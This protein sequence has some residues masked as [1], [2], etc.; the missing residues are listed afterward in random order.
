[1][2]VEHSTLV[3]GLHRLKPVTPNLWI[4]S[5]CWSCSSMA[6]SFANRPSWPSSPVRC[7][8]AQSAVSG[9]SRY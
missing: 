7:N 6:L 4:A 8:A 5:A 2:K 1:V 9:G 3:P